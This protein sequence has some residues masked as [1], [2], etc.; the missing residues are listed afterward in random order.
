MT[1]LHLILLGVFGGSMSTTALYLWLQSRED[2]AISAQILTTQTQT[3]EQLAQM[4]IKLDS[5]KIEIQKSLTNTDLLEIPCS[6]DWMATNTDLL[7]REMF[8][9]LQTREGDAA[10]QDECEQISNMANSITMMQQCQKMGIQ[11]DQCTQVVYR[12]K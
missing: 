12:R 2:D 1:S 8:C 7:C 5:D 11:L 9:R 4:Q 3:I 10:S 6:K